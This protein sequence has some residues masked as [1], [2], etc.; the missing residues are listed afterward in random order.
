MHVK[1]IKRFYRNL[2]YLKK[3]PAM[4]LSLPIVLCMLT[5][6]AVAQTPTWSSD[7]ARI[8][9]AHCT[10]CHHPGGI[11]PSSFMSYPEASAN[12]FSINYAVSNGIMP[13]WPAD[14]NYKHYAHENVLSAAEITALQQWVTNG[15]PQ[16]NMQTAP[17]PPVYND[18]T[19]LGTVD[20]SL[21]MQNY[22]ITSNGDVY[23]NFVLN[24]GLTQ[25]R[26]ATAI[27]VIPGNREIVH[28][29][30]VFMDTTNN[31]INPN[32]AGGTGSNASKLI[33]GYVP[34]ADPYFTPPGTG[35][36][37][38]P[39][40]RIILQMHYAPGSNSLS[41]A[42]KINFKLTP[43]PQ[44]EISVNPI[45]NHF[46]SLTNGPLSI[47]ANQT[48]TF[49]EQVT[50]PGNWTLLYAWPH[51]HMVGRSIKS[52]ATTTT[53][54]DT[55]RFVDVP[56]WDFHWQMNYLF[57]NAVKLNNNSTLRATA[58]YDNTTNNLNNP[59]S[60][61]Q[62]VT[63][64]EGTGDE[65]MMVFFA[66]MP[67]QTGD[68]NLIIDKRILPKS[69]TTFCAGQSVLLKTIEGQGY[70]YQWRRNGNTIGGATAASYTATLGGSYTVS[71]TL[72]NNS[73]VSDPVVVTVNNS[74]TASITP[75]G[76]T[77]F[78]A[79]GS[80]TLN[81]STG[82]GYTYR[83][84]KNDT[85]ISNATASAY[86]A[87]QPG[88]Y[89]VEVY[90]GCYATSAPV[91]VSNTTFTAGITPSGSTTICA[92]SNVTLTATAGSSY[93][94]SNGASTQSISVNQAGNYS[95][96]VTQNSC[97]A[98]A[99]QSVTVNPLPTSFYTYSTGSNTV[100]LVNGSSDAVS[101]SWN[102]GD[103]NTS[104]LANPTHTYS[105][106]GTYTVTLTATNSCGSTQYSTTVNLN[107]TAFNVF[108]ASQGTLSFCQGGSVSISTSP[109]TGYTYQWL[110]NA[111]AITG[112]TSAQYTVTESGTYSLQVYDANSCP[113]T[114]NTITVTVFSN[115]ATPVV[116]YNNGTLQTA[117]S[118]NYEWFK[119]GVST[120]V[121][122][123]QLV[124]SET[125]CYAV[126][127][128]DNNGCSGTS[129][130]ACFFISNV[131]SVEPSQLSLF[132]NPAKDK[133][134]VNTHNLQFQGWAVCS[135]VC[136]RLIQQSEVTN[137]TAAIRL[138]GLTN[139]LYFLTIL[140]NTHRAMLTKKFLKQ[141]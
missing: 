23:R 11:G 127:V 108:I 87:S 92:N 12:A 15:T 35:F 72:G 59:N 29:V 4:K 9:Y 58:Y 8:V 99:A 117:A 88:N 106:M 60:P 56:D 16:G 121:T 119:D 81:A 63:A 37:F 83:W 14:P 80:V 28:H 68:E 118:G 101:Y 36:R 74:P 94:W 30:L 1:N 70:T 128:T 22:T 133:L 91:T 141:E 120:G 95:V 40:T 89:T 111:Q 62:N 31:A 65:M 76:S 126:K 24:T 7:V 96:T 25:T 10:P 84:F 17:A 123:A 105:A 41:D 100:T 73:Q 46:T 6:A 116:S 51:M 77:S 110:S 102:F 21:Q 49:N 18:S 44:R 2:R 86:T 13:P 38:P 125:G 79:G 47:P 93:N 34:G 122:T 69:G 48:K 57:P 42:T 139:G 64:G 97:T 55:V 115:P 50:M 33:Y 109:V 90:N 137:G 75:A 132:P 129:D 61:P 103:G 98:I 43:T 107:C 27:E 112:A 113:A 71:I 124:V 32:S 136:G 131:G 66:Y 114:S 140:D 52:F 19:Q 5:S 45:L 54:N 130:T 26:Y 138:E 39:N 20:L 82:Q 53:P 104:T 85:L 78:C 135:D 67:Y 3:Y 134:F